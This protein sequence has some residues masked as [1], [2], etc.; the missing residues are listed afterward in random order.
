ME[1]E[2]VVDELLTA[3]LESGADG[4]FAL[5]AAP[6]AGVVSPLDDAAFPLE[7]VEAKLGSRLGS[8]VD[9]EG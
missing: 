4:G 7:E 1:F 3:P 8:T 5:S 9:W 6:V 2:G